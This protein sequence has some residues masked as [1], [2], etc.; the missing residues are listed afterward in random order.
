MNGSGNRPAEPGKG[1][2]LDVIVLSPTPTAPVD[3]GNRKR[4]YS[5][6]QGLKERG[7]RIWFLYYPV[8]ADWRRNFPQD[9]LR[10]MQRDWHQVHLIPNTRPLHSAAE[11]THH[12]ID[13]WWDPAIGDFLGWLTARQDF[14]A[15]IVN[16]TYL[17]KAFAFVP[18]STVKIL[19]THDR[20]AGRAEYL[21]RNGVAREFFYTTDEEEAAGLSRADLIWAIKDDEARIFRQLCYRPVLTLTHA[22]PDASITRRHAADDDAYLNLGLFG[23]RN[24]VN[25]INY[26]R[27]LEMAVPI[28]RRS[29]APIRLQVAGSMCDDLPFI[30]EPMVERL[31]RVA[32]ADD[33]Y[34]RVDAVVIPMSFSTGL[35]IKMVEALSRGLPVLAHAHASEG[36]AVTHPWHRLSTLEAL[37][38]ACIELA[39]SRDKL[40]ALATAS[41]EAHAAQ[42]SRMAATLDRSMAFVRSRTQT[43]L[44]L[45][46]DPGLCP[47]SMLAAALRDWLHYLHH[48][49][50]V[51]LYLD[52]DLTGPV[53][54]SLAELA[55]VARFRLILRPDARLA[56]EAAERLAAAQLGLARATFDSCIAGLGVMA[57]LTDASARPERLAALARCGAPAF[58]LTDFGVAADV[59]GHGAAEPILVSSDPARLARSARPGQRTIPVFNF[60]TVPRRLHASWKAEAQDRHA[61]LLL[62]AGGADLLLILTATEIARCWGR[63][64]GR[65]SI[66]ASRTALEALE[67][68]DWPLERAMLVS[69]HGIAVEPIA[70]EDAALQ[71]RSLGQRPGWAVDLC[72]DADGFGPVREI[73]DLAGVPRIALLPATRHS[74][75]PEIRPGALQSPFLIDLFAGIERLATSEAALA[76]ASRECR[77]TTARN[78]RNDGG[79][80]VLWRLLADLQ[81]QAK[82][83]RT[84]TSQLALTWSAAV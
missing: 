14:D 33:F 24:N 9:S 71:V 50:K 77:E 62:W 32:W 74:L 70:V 61:A 65:L 64:P 48:L 56:E 8:E 80:A 12:A 30:D 20:F 82:R 83:R 73:L 35:K 44:V 41:R 68:G 84:A 81:A 45:L 63:R 60:N 66:L 17:C 51:C 13:E 67:S 28:F 43:L 1:S 2:P 53:V 79:R 37:C 69:R 16:Y 21:E 57:C 23:A 59:P 78:R 4:I 29:L 58:M 5:V 22:D 76:E 19:D 54:A 7:V 27:F 3:F 38:E 40:V 34:S 72:G 15:I 18:P 52:M 11:A 39:F 25:V 75:T 49:E 6:C 42:K 26:R 47:E 46:T 36:V 10:Q 55:D 31:G